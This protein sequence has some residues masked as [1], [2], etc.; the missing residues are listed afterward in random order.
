MD[1]QVT[2][3]NGDK[4]V[5][6]AFAQS[7]INA[8]GVRSSTANAYIDPNPY[9]YNLHIMTRALVTRIIVRDNSAIGVEFLRAG[10]T[11]SVRARKEVIVSGGI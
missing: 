6:T 8:D 11:Q 9:P 3:I 1:F 7:F 10:K 5:G 4:Q 2:D